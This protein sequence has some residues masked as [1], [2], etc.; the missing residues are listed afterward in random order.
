MV[1]SSSSKGNDDDDEDWEVLVLCPR[2][3]S[4]KADLRGPMS[5]RSVRRYRVV[6]IRAQ[7]PTKRDP[8]VPPASLWYNE[9]T[10]NSPSVSRERRRTPIT[11]V[12]AE[13]L[14][15]F[16][17]LIDKDRIPPS[18]SSSIGVGERKDR[19]SVWVHCRLV[20][21]MVA[22]ALVSIDHCRFEGL[23]QGK[24][25]IEVKGWSPNP[26]SHGRQAR[27]APPMACLLHS[28]KSAGGRRY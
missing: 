8:L 1:F 26:V 20:L 13:I 17:D 5:A 24:S 9:G 12:V 6:S 21:A 15:D 4:L 3:R 16:P 22:L 27:V 19:R 28:H 11:M 7:A 18:V 2:L 10:A 14:H 23:H 25:G